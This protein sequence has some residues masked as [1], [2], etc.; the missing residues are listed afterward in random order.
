M[1]HAKRIF[2]AIILGVFFSSGMVGA[3]SKTKYIFPPY[4]SPKVVM[5]FYFDSPHKMAPALYWIRSL[6]NPLSE[7]PYDHSLDFMNIVVVIHGREMVT[8][9][10]KNYKKYKTVV[11]RIRYYASRGVKFRICGLAMKDFGYKQEDFHDF[12]RI[13]PSAMA[14]V[15]HWQSKG[16]GLLIPKVL[17]KK[18]RNSDIR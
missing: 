16:Y 10:R 13:V 3:K 12:V 9:A 2:I 7:S 18:D 15:V 11:E 6:V 1:S 8:L 5:E 4:K 17:V 14:D